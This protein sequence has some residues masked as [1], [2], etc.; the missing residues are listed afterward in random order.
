[1]KIPFHNKSANGRATHALL[2]NLE[3]LQNAKSK[4]QKI[5]KQRQQTTYKRVT[6]CDRIDV[7]Y[8]N[9]IH[10]L[11]LN[12][13]FDKYKINYNTLRHIVKQYSSS[14]R[15]GSQK[16]KRKVEEKQRN[17]QKRKPISKSKEQD[18]IVESR[19]EP[20]DCIQLR[21]HNCKY[22]HCCNMEQSDCAHDTTYHK[23]DD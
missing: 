11:D 9:A 22:N 15:V 10:G 6:M 19:A 20:D 8:D 2:I 12:Q 16:Y 13:L 21:E 14:G 18:Q 3:N 1:M 7:I 23:L 5:R 17:T 4:V